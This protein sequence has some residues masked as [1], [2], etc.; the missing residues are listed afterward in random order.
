MNFFSFGVG[1]RL[2]REQGPWGVNKFSSVATSY[3]LDGLQGVSSLFQG[4]FVCLFNGATMALL[5]MHSTMVSSKDLLVLVESLIEFNA[6]TRSIVMKEQSKVGKGIEGDGGDGSWFIDLPDLDDIMSLQPIGIAM[7][8][9]SS[10][11]AVMSLSIESR[12]LPIH[13]PGLRLMSDQDLLVTSHGQE[14]QR[15]E[16]NNQWA[17]KRAIFL[18]SQ[19]GKDISIPLEDLPIERLDKLFGTLFAKVTK[20]DGM[21]YPKASLMN[22]LNAFN[23]IIRRAS[24]IQSV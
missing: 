6:I 9:P 7:A 15:S 18:I 3:L 16:H 10:E 2:A 12:V 17:S 23:R 22:M 20:V 8:M 19:W 4:L 13:V 11:P 5:S 14:R 21:I 24:E 1:R